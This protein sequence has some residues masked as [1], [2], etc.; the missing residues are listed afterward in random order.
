M[1]NQNEKIRANKLRI[2]QPTNVDSLNWESESHTVTRCK[3]QNNFGSKIN[4]RKIILKIAS[5]S[6]KNK[7][8]L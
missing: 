4:K 5:Y 6:M 3:E 7:L 2:G 8:L 1:G